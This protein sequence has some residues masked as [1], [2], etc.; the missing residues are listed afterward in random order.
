MAKCI[1]RVGIIFFAVILISLLIASVLV[2]GRLEKDNPNT[3]NA[4]IADTE[5][6]PDITL[7]GDSTNMAALWI[8]AIDKSIKENKEIKVLLADNWF[9]PISTNNAF[10][11]GIGFTSSG[12]ILVPAGAKIKLELNGKTIDRRLTKNNPIVNGRIFHIE[13][14]LTITD[15]TYNGDAVM[16]IYKKSKEDKQF[17]DMRIRALA[18][19]KITGGASSSVGAITV[20]KTTGILNFYGGMIVDNYAIGNGAALG[21]GDGATVN[22]YNGLIYGNIGQQ[23]GGGVYV[24]GGTFEMY[25]GFVM[26]NTAGRY[27]GGI[28]SYGYNNSQTGEMIK[29]KVKIHNGIIAHNASQ[30]GTGVSICR[31]SEGEM[32]DGEVAYNNSSGNSAGILVWETQSKFDLYNGKIHHNRSVYINPGA[33]GGTGILSSTELNVYGGEIT[34]NY[35]DTAKEDVIVYGSGIYAT[36]GI[37]RLA[38]VTVTG[39]EIVSEVGDGKHS[40]GG[41]ISFGL[42]VNFQLGTNVKVFDNFAHG[43]PSDL[44]I[45][46]GAKI[47]IT[48][49]LAKGGNSSYIGIKLADDYGTGVF[50]NGYGANNSS[51]PSEYFFSNNGIKLATLNNS[52]VSFEKT[53]NSE[54]YDFV[55]LENEKR[56]NYK[57]NNLTHAVN[58]YAK[59]RLVN[60]GVLV[61]GNI[62]PNTSV[63][64]FISNINFERENVRLYDSSNKL[65][66]DKG[67]SV[68][69]VDSS[70]YDKKL[71]LAVGTGWRLETYN[72][73]VK[74]EDFK[75]SVL[76]DLNGDGR[77]S[78]SD[79]TYLR[80]VANNK[81][82]YQNLSVETKLAGLIINKGNVTSADSEIILNVIAQKLTIDLF[83]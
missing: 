70:L 79:C 40:Y 10:G 28:Q 6:V 64:T 77:V 31:E 56:H 12:C 4:I 82:L 69:G 50:T 14:T 25:N 7:T 49:T 39:N 59:S 24:Y 73:S 19:G 52:E 30:F 15:N 22:M 58:D 34:D 55:Y 46:K 68:A 60:G 29:G 53:V 36:A 26:N 61:L 48:D 37:V 38:N 71:E 35:Y 81:A 66:Y 32:Y 41:G 44:R 74:I 20:E 9:A 11:S 65:I 18:I 2:V 1:K 47:N 42:N 62:A 76:G 78:A 80:E 54:V 17:L 21:V 8:N 51:N 75:L 23:F 45:E 27:G 57:D 63:N 33:N 13:G 72:G 67:N 83:Y 16:D 5:F 43:V 3:N